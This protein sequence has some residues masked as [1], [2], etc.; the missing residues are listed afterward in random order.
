MAALINQRI[1][2]VRKADA[3]VSFCKSLH[4]GDMQFAEHGPLISILI[5]S[6]IGSP[7]CAGMCGGFVALYSHPIPNHKT[8]HLAYSLGRLTTYLTLGVTGALLGRTFDAATG[9]AR[10]S[11]LVVGVILI[12]MGVL[13]LLGL[14]ADFAP[15]ITARISGAV[16][17]LAKPAFALPVKLRPFAIGLVTTLL[18]CG[19]LYTF[20]AIAVGSS[21]LWSAA[22]IMLVFWLGTLPIMLTLGVTAGFLTERLGRY[23]P[24]ITALLL[25][26]AGIFSLSIHLEHADH[27]SHH[28]HHHEH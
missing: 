25:I 13:R 5:A 20:V 26:L 12:A 23:L 9:I 28:H 8:A 6:L 4:T 27:S 22:A 14:G 24:R 11:A 17:R 16:S 21:N 18:P 19:W 1:V 2:G 7:H 15:R 3:I 10:A